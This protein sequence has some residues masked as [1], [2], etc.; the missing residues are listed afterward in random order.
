MW[1]SKDRYITIKTEFYDKIKQKL[2]KTLWA[3]DFEEV[4]PKIWRA[5]KTEVRWHNGNTW[6]KMTTSS[7]QANP[8]IPRW[9]FQPNILKLTDKASMDLIEEMWGVYGKVLKLRDERD[10]LKTELEKLQKGGAK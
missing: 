10:Q 1:I 7:R 5:N 9:F 6:T 8:G 3:W 2:Q 4:L